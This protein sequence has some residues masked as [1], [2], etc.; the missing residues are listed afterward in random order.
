[1]SEYCLVVL[2]EAFVFIVAFPIIDYKSVQ[3]HVEAKI[4]SSR[5]ACTR[6]HITQVLG[7]YVNVPGSPHIIYKLGPS[8][9][10]KGVFE[11]LPNF[12]LCFVNGVFWLSCI[13]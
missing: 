13:Q 12:Y 10:R 11:P 3:L 1:M 4:L 5:N 8:F 2:G 6:Q 7:L 9:P